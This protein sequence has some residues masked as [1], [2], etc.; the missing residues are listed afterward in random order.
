MLIIIRHG[1]TDWNIQPRI[2]QGHLDIGL[3]QTGKEQA[4]AFAY[5]FDKKI[6]VIY[7]SPLKRAA[8]TA[9]I[10]KT[11][12]EE[13]F[14]NR[15]LLHFDSRL[16][17]IDCGEWHGLYYNDIINNF[18]QEWQKIKNL[19]LSFSFPKGESIRQLLARFLES[20]KEIV[21]KYPEN[22]KLIMVITHGGPMRAFKKHILKEENI[23]VSNLDHFYV[24]NNTILSAHSP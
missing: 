19:D 7:S 4:K 24:D 23:T 9:E 15:L 14:K 1:E 6:E 22:E 11:I 13:K 2:F 12:L 10:I 5:G 21:Q 17:E 18:P 3:N 16:K 20:L 8:E